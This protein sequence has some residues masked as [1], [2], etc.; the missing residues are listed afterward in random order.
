MITLAVQAAGRDLQNITF[1]TFDESIKNNDYTVEPEESL[2]FLMADS[3][4][5]ESYEIIINSY[6]S[7]FVSVIDGSNKYNNFKSIYKK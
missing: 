1:H 3:D 5:Q 6:N 2:E 4:M 7:L